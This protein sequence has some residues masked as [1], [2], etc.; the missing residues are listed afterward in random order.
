M[1]PCLVYGTLQSHHIAVKVDLNSGRT[2][3]GKP[4]VLIFTLRRNIAGRN[5]SRA[6]KLILLNSPPPAPADDFGRTAR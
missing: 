3:G 1:S 6:C 4:S 2:P 5:S